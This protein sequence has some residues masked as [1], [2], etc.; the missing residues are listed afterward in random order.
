MPVSDLLPYEWYN[1]PNI[2]V[3]TLKDFRRFAGNA[4][5]K[6]LKEV[7]ISTYHHESHGKIITFMPD[8]FAA[9]G[10]FLLGT[11]GDV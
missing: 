11:K 8:L 7:A 9:Y 10:I 4:G 3:I 1:T 6:I 5:F 2:R